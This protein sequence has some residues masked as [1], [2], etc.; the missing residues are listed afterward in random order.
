MTINE[1]KCFEYASK[2]P[3]TS[4]LTETLI[5]VI[6]NSSRYAGTNW[7]YSD[8]MSISIAPVSNYSYPYDFRGVVQHEAGGHGFGKTG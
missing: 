6:T 8:G 3:L 2:V 1:S 5:T 7:S 4:D